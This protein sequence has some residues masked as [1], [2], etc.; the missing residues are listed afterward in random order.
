MDAILSKVGLFFATILAIVSSSSYI[1]L[2]KTTV[3]LNWKT[4]D[5]LTVITKVALKNVGSQQARFEV[6]SSQ[7]WASV[8][9]E[10]QYNDRSFDI[11]AG[12]ALNLA[13]EVKPEELANGPHQAAI[14]VKAVNDA[15]GTVHETQTLFVNVNKNYTPSSTA[16]TST[17]TVSTTPA[18]SNTATP[19]TSPA[20]TVTPG[21]TVVKTPTPSPRVTGSATPKTSPQVSPGASKSPAVTLIQGSPT[22][23]PSVSGEPNTPSEDGIFERAFKKILSWFGFGD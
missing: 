17:A 23:G 2:E 12:G 8:Y 3:D 10:D 6:S 20:T 7:T 13:I 1:Y 4:G 18:S 5:S 19:T 21:Q 11:F 16:P 14:T 15:D 22:P 9:R